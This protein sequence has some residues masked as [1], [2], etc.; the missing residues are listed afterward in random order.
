MSKMLIIIFVAIVV[1]GSILIYSLI[2]PKNR[3][4]NRKLNRAS[5]KSNHIEPSLNPQDDEMDEM[6]D[7]VV[8]SARVLKNEDRDYQ[9]EKQAKSA[10][11]KKVAK[12]QSLIMLYIMAPKG[13]PYNG[14]ELLQ[15]LLSAGLRFGEMQIFH[16]YE[17][18]TGRGKILFSLA[19][20]TNPGTFELSKMGG[21]SCPGLILFLDLNKVQMPKKAFE[22]MLETVGQLSEDLGGEVLDESRQPLS[23][24]KA[25]KLSQ[26]IRQFEQDQP[27]PDLFAV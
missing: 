1:V 17:Q 14:Y 15:A 20:A 16:R 7:G 22:I 8:S 5:K 10:S 24:E 2:R 18:K 25:V 23:K 19:S 3:K 26:M 13:Q 11:P 12:E 27:T 9:Q 21:F 6:D 4:S